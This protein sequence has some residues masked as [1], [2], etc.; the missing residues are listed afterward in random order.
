MA[1][2]I[3][4]MTATCAGRGLAFEKFDLARREDRRIAAGKAVRGTPT[5]LFVDPEGQE[6]ARL[7]GA[8]DLGTLHRATAALM[9]ETCAGFTAL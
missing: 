4:A 3:R 2:L 8:V 5:L 6:V 7:I 9:G 1:P